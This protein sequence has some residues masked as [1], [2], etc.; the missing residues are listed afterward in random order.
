MRSVVLVCSLVCILSV[1]PIAAAETPSSVLG[2]QLENF[3]LRGTDGK[4]WT[5]SG[6]QDKKA[7]VVVFVGTECPVNNQYIPRLGELAGEYGSQG[8][9]F[10]V[11][12]SNTQDTP[13]RVTEHAQKFK[14]ALPVLKDP[15]SKVAD[16]FGAR[17]TPEAFLL[18]SARKVVYRGRI[19]DQYGVSFARPKATRRDLAEAIEDVLAGKP[20]RTPETEA[21]G[22][23]IARPVKSKGTTSVTFTRD[24]SRLLQQH[25]QE[26]HRAGQIG[27]MPLLTY[28]DA[29]A[30]SETIK[31]VVDEGRM[32][33]WHADPKHG[34]FAN[35]RRLPKADREALLAWID[36]GCPKGDDKDL[37]S[38]KTF[39]EGWRIGK[40]DAVYE[41]PRE[42][43]IPAKTTR[44]IRYQYFVAPTNFDEDR[45]IQAA[46]AR[47]GNPAVVHHIIVYIVG[48]GQGAGRGPDGIGQGFLV[49]YAPGDMPAIFAPGTAKKLPKGAALAF[50]MHYTPNGT[51]QTDRSSVGLIFSKTPPKHEMKTRSIANSR[52][53]I[54][55]GD[56]NYK[57]VSAST[58]RE[59]SVLYSFLPHMHLRGK[60]FLYKV[61]F[62]DGKEEVLLSVPRYDFN[63]QSNYRL[64]KPLML[65][66][67]TRIE[68][69]AHFDN[70]AKNKNNP[71][72][73][74][75]VRW[76]EQT[77]EEMLIGFVDYAVVPKTGDR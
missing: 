57:A 77:W 26:C 1:A 33:P 12:N 74:K 7:V 56:E 62:P 50:Q 53:A 8:V 72:P 76:G 11:I 66:A 22:C 43:K 47:A 18:D 61:I 14:L 67:G 32:P 41:M 54:P 29:S 34:T 48:P 25:C 30:W 5:L 44:G 46:E 65:P 20:V 52:I 37:P 75:L 4:E 45:W 68:C 73:T 70:S 27:P 9:A 24:I 15:G 51:E 38:P 3:T 39:A 60:D 35:D 42:F 17:R 28:E 23:L 6:V 71:D 16:Q 58:F 36:A 49:G 55:A 2:K 13:A 59:D 31:E 40:P 10:V 69:T 63:W 64:A 19:D 21:P